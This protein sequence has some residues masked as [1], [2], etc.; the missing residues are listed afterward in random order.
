MTMNP[1]TVIEEARSLVGVPFRHQGRD[2]LGID[3]VGVPIYA[4]L[5]HGALPRDFQT[6]AY[7]RLPTGALIE[8]LKAHCTPATRPVPASLVVIAWRNVAA[9]VGIL[10][11][12][13]IIHAYE[14]VGEVVEHGYRGRWVRLTHST[15]LLPGVQ[16]E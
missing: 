13:T 14:R 8:R 9:H 11:G 2:M 7:G 12:D 1:A 6:A 10:T 16:Y 4:L 3:C 15:W 5:R